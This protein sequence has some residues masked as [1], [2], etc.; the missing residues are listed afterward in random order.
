MSK[1]RQEH[2]RSTRTAAGDCGTA[3]LRAAIFEHQKTRPRR[4]IGIRR[5][6]IAQRSWIPPKEG[7]TLPRSLT[8]KSQL[9]C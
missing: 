5:V 3:Q 1:K 8:L 9:I 2:N 7:N 6:L 4:R